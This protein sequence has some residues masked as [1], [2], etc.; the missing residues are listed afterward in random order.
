MIAYHGTTVCGI[1]V[2]KPFANPASNLDYPCVYFSVNQALASVYIW[3]Y[4]F[5]WM[6]FEIRE[7]GVPV[8][9]ETFS[10]GLRSFYEGVKGVIYTAEG[11]FETDANTTIRHAVISREPVPI[12]RADEVEDA[13]ERILRYEREG[14]LCIRRFDQLTEAERARDRRMVA[15]TIQRLRLWEEIQT[16]ERGEAGNPLAPFVRDTFPDIWEEALRQE[17][18]SE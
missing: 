7:D 8:Y 9:N 13:Y 14:R 12:Q 5:K 6:T 18:L 11:D 15:N 4:P 3:R 1:R 2:L 16:I 17:N 10:N